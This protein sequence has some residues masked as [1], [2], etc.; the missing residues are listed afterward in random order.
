MVR[1]IGWQDLH[2]S[3][4][5]V[6]PVVGFGGICAFA[7]IDPQGY[8]EVFEGT[9]W[10]L[11][12]TV[13]TIPLLAALIA[14]HLLTNPLVHSDIRPLAWVLLLMLGSFF[15]VAE[16]TGWGRDV[17]DAPYPEWWPGTGGIPVAETE[18][19][20]N[21]EAIRALL[22]ALAVFVGLLFPLLAWMFPGRSITLSWFRTIWPTYVCIPVL[23][24]SVLSRLPREVA[25]AKISVAENLV[26][27]HS[28]VG[29]MFVYL[30][31]LIYVLS[32]HSR[33]GYIR[34]HLPD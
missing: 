34:Q 17:F 8:L 16:D 13:A 15:L 33:L 3:L 4:W 25:E 28:E 7:L 24:L 9:S 6:L 10:T 26:F 11:E 20:Q 32:L 12:L 5:L 23:V 18:P 1:T 14:V 22:Q 2:W 27:R 19:D 21:K 29:E 30:F 31:L